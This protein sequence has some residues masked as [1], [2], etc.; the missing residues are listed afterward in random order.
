M[1]TASGK[2]FFFLLSAA[3]RWRKWCWQFLNTTTVLTSSSEKRYSEYPACERPRREH[4]GALLTSP[5]SL[6][7]RGLRST[8]PRRACPAAAAT[9]APMRSSAGGPNTARPR[10]DTPTGAATAGDA[11]TDRPSFPSASQQLSRP[12]V[13]ARAAAAVRRSAAGYSGL[14]TR[15]PPDQFSSKRV[16]KQFVWAFTHSFCL[17][18]TSLFSVPILSVRFLTPVND[19]ILYT[20]AILSPLEQQTS[21]QPSQYRL[22]GP[23]RFSHLY[24]KHCYPLLRKRPPSSLRLKFPG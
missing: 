10:R 6:H 1:A 7:N 9:T 19:N 18:F 16:L 24:L 17:S 3:H 15:T 4:R 14:W 13:K 21:S 22:I 20:Q 11:A 5:P 12:C 2:V 23:Q 8:R